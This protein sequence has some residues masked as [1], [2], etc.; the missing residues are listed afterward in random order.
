VRRVAWV[1]VAALAVVAAACTSNSTSTPSATTSGGSGHVAHTAFGSNWTVYHGAPAGSG[2]DTA[3]TDLNPAHAL[4]TSPTLDGQVYGEP[5]VEDGRIIVAT[6]NDTVYALA[7]NT[8]AVLWKNHVG[9]P[10]PSS[11]LPCGDIGPS[12]GIT[13]TPVIDANRSEIYAVADEF[14]GGTAE[15]LLVGLDL[16]TGALLLNQPADAPGSHPRYQLQRTGLNLTGGRVIFGYGGNDGDCETP[17]NPYHGWIVAIPETGGTMQTFEV[18]SGAGDTEGAVWMG[19][20]APEV[21]AG[22]NIW[23]ATGNGSGSS[24]T[25]PDNGDSV[26]ELSSQLHELQSFTPSTWKHDNDNDFDLGSEAPALVPGGVVFQAGKSQTAFLMNEAALGGIGGQTD[27]ATSFCGNDVDGGTAVS[28]STVY[29]P[30]MN[31]LEAVNVNTATKKFVRSPS[32]P[33]WQTST[34]SPGPPVLA[35]GLVWTIDQ[36]NGTL[37]GLNPATG[38]AT[39]QFSTGGGDNHFPTPSV[40]DGLLLAPGNKAV[41]AFDGPGGAP[42]APPPAPPRP[43]YSTA[44]SDG[45]VFTFGGAV[46][47]GSEGG[48]H[49]DAPI[50]GMTEDPQTGGYWLVASDGGVFSFGAPFHGSEGGHHLDAPIVGMAEDPVAG[51]L[52]VAAD[53]G[54]FTF[55]GAPFHGSEGGHPLD[56]PVVGMAPDA[57]TGG[58]WLVASDGGIFTFDA[59]FRGS[60]GGHRLTAPVVGMA[61]D[62][63]TGGYWLVGS[64]GGIFS[65]AAPFFGS[66]GGEPLDAPMVAIGAYQ[67][68][69]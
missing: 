34:N 48:H 65:F 24:T 8:G 28:G 1:L 37:Y 12:V 64:D 67:P 30:C 39:Q 14:V 58:Y 57:T 10:V 46:F 43:G 52:L 22:G 40:A 51:Y 18:D 2:A 15:H 17:S 50:V 26:I 60:E 41:L 25:D 59:P 44:A 32:F 13:G 49:L 66:E 16:F 11:D 21:D 69:V 62:A 19:G 45:G 42:P 6:E 36:A 63:T 38:S 35:G 53:G 68:P 56:A 7:A 55:G 29:V 54:I 33:L 5:L 27:I 31:G 47:H 4:W 61:P 23:F 20:A 9:T 3:G